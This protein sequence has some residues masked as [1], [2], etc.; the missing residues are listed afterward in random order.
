M[1]TKMLNNEEMESIFE[2]ISL[3]TEVP[4]TAVSFWNNIE[5][6]LQ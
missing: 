5:N 1:V 4:D 6:N 2:E 3:Y